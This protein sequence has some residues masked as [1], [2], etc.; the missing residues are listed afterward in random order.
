MAPHGVR[1]GG[2]S[3]SRTRSGRS[4]AEDGVAVARASY[5]A[6]W[7]TNRE[8][9]LARRD[10]LCVGFAVNTLKGRSRDRPHRDSMSKAGPKPRRAAYPKAAI[11]TAA[12][13]FETVS[14]ACSTGRSKGFQASPMTCS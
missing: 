6:A 4:A 12:A 5:P 7:T 14:P 9:P 10:A 8:G 1:R 11:W 3:R 13:F 2:I